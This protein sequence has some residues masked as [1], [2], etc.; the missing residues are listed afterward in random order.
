MATNVE[1]TTSRRLDAVLSAERNRAERRKSLRTASE[2]I[3]HAAPYDGTNVPARHEFKNVVARELSP[4]GI[5]FY[6]DRQPSSDSFLL[7]FG[8]PGHVQGEHGGMQYL[9]ARVVHCSHLP[10]D[11]NQQYLIGCSFSDRVGNGD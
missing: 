5:S 4:T 3:I 9:S 1:H 2:V 8:E 10:L 11:R 7:M 6:S